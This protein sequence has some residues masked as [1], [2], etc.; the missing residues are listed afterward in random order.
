MQELP[1]IPESIRQWTTVNRRENGDL[2]I[3]CKPESP[4]HHRQID[5]I[6]GLLGPDEPV[7]LGG[8]ASSRRYSVLSE[9]FGNMVR[10]HRNNA[11]PRTIEVVIAPDGATTVTNRGYVTP[12]IRD[13]LATKFEVA[14]ALS[15]EQAADRVTRIIEGDE[16]EGH[17]D[18]HGEET[19]GM[20][21]MV[22]RAYSEGDLQL[23]FFPDDTRKKGPATMERFELKVELTKGKGLPMPEASEIQHKGPVRSFFP[24][25]QLGKSG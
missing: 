16:Y 1:Q 25:V 11:P 23:T 19:G 3:L 24:H 22:Q 8:L 6:N 5:F 17:E 20:G 21:L 15:Q 9:I 2:V 12:Q 4:S 18:V 10:H 7:D 13:R 14:Q